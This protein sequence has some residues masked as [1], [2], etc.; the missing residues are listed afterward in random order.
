MSGAGQEG[1]ATTQRDEVTVHVAAP[2]DRVWTLVADITRMGEWSPENI[3]GRWRGGATGPAVGARFVGTNRH[4]WLR[5]RTHCTVVECVPPRA[6]AFDVAESATRWGFEVEPEGA[7][8][9]VTEWRVH[10]GRAPWYARA[11]AGSG[12]LGRDREQM[13]IDGMRR[14]LHRMRAELER[15]G[16]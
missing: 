1:S 13:M 9:R 12:L 16:R 4:G 7:G 3:G 14:T 5:W 2:S 8:S 6:F 10:G 15:E 11:L